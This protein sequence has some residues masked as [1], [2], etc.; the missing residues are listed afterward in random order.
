MVLA[1]DFR[2]IGK[3]MRLI[4]IKT[5]IG[6]EV[7]IWDEDHKPIEST[8][9]PLQEHQ[10]LEKMHDFTIDDLVRLFPYRGD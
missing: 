10:L 5:M 2:R 3:K 6:V 8:V 9:K 7:Q 4:Y 1:R